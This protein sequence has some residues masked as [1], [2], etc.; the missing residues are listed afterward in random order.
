MLKGVFDFTISHLQE[1]V[2]L[3][4]IGTVWSDVAV[5]WELKGQLREQDAISRQ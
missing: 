5:N 3:V 2:F 4:S 1:D